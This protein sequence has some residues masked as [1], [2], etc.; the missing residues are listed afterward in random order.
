MTSID[1]GS[2]YNQFF[3]ML[4]SIAFFFKYKFPTYKKCQNLTF[5]SNFLTSDDLATLSSKLRRRKL[6]SEVQLACLTQSNLLEITHNFKFDPKRKF[7]RLTHY[8]ELLLKNIQKPETVIAR[9]NARVVKLFLY[10]KMK[11]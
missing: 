9:T 10:A 2:P 5:Y 6:H 3:G 4:T 7:S 1:L 8:F 11:L